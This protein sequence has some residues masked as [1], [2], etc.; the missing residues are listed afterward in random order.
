M[1]YQQTID[2]LYAQLPMFS[3]IGSAAYKEDLH[4]TIA[5]CN[6]IGNPQNNFKTIHIAGT[7]GKGSTSHMLAAILQS[8]GYKT[9]LYTSPHIKDFRER[10]RINGKMI[11][12]DFVI[13][14]VAKTTEITAER[15]AQI[16]SLNEI[17]KLR[18]QTLAQMALAWLLKDKRITTVLI[19]AS[20]V[21][22]LDDNLA[23]LDNPEF[24]KQELNKI[25]KI[26][27]KQI[28]K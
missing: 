19:G 23:C 8:A 22:Q 2:Y 12:K 17:A 28:S 11:S 21:A 24:S 3:R 14:F 25:E 15:L 9:G 20:S 7:N 4:N 18:N 1:T 27:R 5:L 6:S 16:N 13:D 26:L 10:I